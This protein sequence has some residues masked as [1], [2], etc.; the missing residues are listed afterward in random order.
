[1]TRFY[2]CYLCLTCFNK[3]MNFRIPRFIV[4]H[5]VKD[6]S[7]KNGFDYIGKIPLL[8][9][10]TVEISSK[11]RFYIEECALL[12]NPKDIYI[13]NGTDVEY[14]QMLNILQKSGTIESLPKYENW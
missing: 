13:C 12:C 11:L 5:A 8:N 3:I 6:P 9:T 1:M 10:C 2:L 7:L 14:M 4:T